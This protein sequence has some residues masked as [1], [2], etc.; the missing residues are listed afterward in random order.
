MVAYVNFHTVSLFLTALTLGGMVFFTA[1]MAPV[2][3]RALPREDA[4][5][6][7]RAAFP[8]YYRVMM[9]AM[10]LAALLIYYRIEA[11]W[12]AGVAV[13][14]I[15]CDIGIRPRL[16]PLREARAAG[17]EAAGTAFARL[18]R[19]SVILNFIQLAVVLIVFFRLAK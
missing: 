19:L 5:A 16:D 8:V 15:A 1:V 9:I 10:L 17:D 2:V 13:V 4:A 18:H 3:F 11:V 7:M 14:F 12:L 6:L